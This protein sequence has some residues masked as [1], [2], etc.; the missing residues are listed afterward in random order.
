MN[1]DFYRPVEKGLRP[2]GLNNKFA[3]EI[4][5]EW[6]AIYESFQKAT[7]TLIAR[8]SEDSPSHKLRV[9]FTGEKLNPLREIVIR[10]A[11]KD[12]EG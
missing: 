7:E 8:V 12:E 1:T 9:L 4:V 2:D 3:E 10:F 6:I 11:N 5:M